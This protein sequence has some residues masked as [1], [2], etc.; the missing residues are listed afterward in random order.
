[1]GDDDQVVVNEEGEG[2][3]G[4]ELFGD[5]VIDEPTNMVFGGIFDSSF[6]TSS[7]KFTSAF[8]TLSFILSFVII[9]LYLC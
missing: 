9:H 4:D 7:I 8:F 2:D 1:M 6:I 5:E 3:E